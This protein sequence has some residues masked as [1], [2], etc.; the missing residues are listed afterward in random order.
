MKHGAL[1]AVLAIAAGLVSNAAPS[2]ATATGPP[3]GLSESG[4]VLWNFEGL[5]TR[6]FG[7]ADDVGVKT[8][9]YSADF[10]GSPTR[11]LFA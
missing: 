3:S 2:S 7:R 9:D 8:L 6:T 4:R 10:V 1:I 11:W 5:L